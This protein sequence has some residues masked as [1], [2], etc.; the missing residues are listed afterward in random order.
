MQ[1]KLIIG[2]HLLKLISVNS[3]MFLY[4]IIDLLKGKRKKPELNEEDYEND[5]NINH[6][7][8]KYSF[9]SGIMFKASFMENS[10]LLDF[11]AGTGCLF[12]ILYLACYCFCWVSP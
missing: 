10:F 1:G 11:T 12:G 7:E 9:L 6:I 8:H 3:T 5:D 2:L 4:V